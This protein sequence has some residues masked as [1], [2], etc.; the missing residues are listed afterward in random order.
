MSTS[1]MMKKLI[2]LAEKKK[3]EKEAEQAKNKK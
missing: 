1:K 3:A 2:E